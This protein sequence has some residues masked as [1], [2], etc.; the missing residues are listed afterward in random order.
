MDGWGGGVTKQKQRCR[1]EGGGTEVGRVR[2]GESL[3]EQ[4]G[5]AKT[6]TDPSPDSGRLGSRGY[7][8]QDKERALPSALSAGCLYWLQPESGRYT[9]IPVSVWRQDGQQA[10]TLGQVPLWL[11]RQP[12]PHVG[13]GDACTRNLWEHMADEGLQAGN[14]PGHR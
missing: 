7:R 4:R 8:V 2:A 11:L 9:G 6:R 10:L 12:R 5:R 3:P 14:S 1:G 13:A